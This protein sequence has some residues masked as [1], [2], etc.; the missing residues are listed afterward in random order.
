MKYLVTL[1]EKLENDLLEVF[2]ESEAQVN[3]VNHLLS[4]NCSDES[5]ENNIFIASLILCQG[6]K[7]F[8]GYSSDQCI[9]YISS[10]KEINLDSVANS[11]DMTKDELLDSIGIYLGLGYE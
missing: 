6:F 11:R 7:K 3:C 5:E 4:E 10:I 2:G 1:P 9:D 8:K